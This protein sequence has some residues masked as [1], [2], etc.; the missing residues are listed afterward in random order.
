MRS[1]RTINFA[2]HLLLI[3]VIE[4]A[5]FFY[6]SAEPGIFPSP[7]L[8]RSQMQASCSQQPDEEREQLTVQFAILGYD[9]NNVPFVKGNVENTTGICEGYY[10]LLL[11]HVICPSLL[12]EKLNAANQWSTI[13]NISGFPS[14]WN[15]SLPIAYRRLLI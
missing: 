3:L 11:S 15:L 7:S 6:F 9:S 4:M 13:R 14:H 8:V 12:F 5:A 2:L 1:P 10:K